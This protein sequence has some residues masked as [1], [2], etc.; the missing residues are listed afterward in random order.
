M[1]HFNECTRREDCP[2]IECRLERIERLITVVLREQQMNS[3]AIQQLLD[4]DQAESVELGV[5]AQ[6]ATDT[7]TRVQALIA[8]LQGSA[9]PAVQQVA[10]DLQQH[11]TAMATIGSALAQ[12]APAQGSS[13]PPAGGTPTGPVL[14][15]T[16][17][18][19]TASS[20]TPA[21]GDTVKLEA[22]VE[23]NPTGT[24]PTGSVTLTDGTGA[25]I[26]T[27]TL[28]ATGG[29]EF[30]IPS[31]TAGTFTYTAAYGGDSANAASTSTPVVVTAA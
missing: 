3:Q 11:V 12:I 14:V 31:I 6:A 17:T 8:T 25:T 9:D 19:L 20:T 23:E 30:D 15:V 4:A 21:V 22:I 5:I 1:S 7:S 28:D 26:G 27:V 13:T 2:E 16:T 10:A 24:V 18:T 29:A